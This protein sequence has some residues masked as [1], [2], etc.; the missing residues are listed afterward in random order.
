MTG[1]V[2]VK[3]LL[4]SQRYVKLVGRNVGIV[5][6][7]LLFDARKFERLVRFASSDGKVPERLLLVK[8]SEVTLA[9]E[10]WQ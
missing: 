10:G 1:I 9:R 5:P 2:P 3:S 7:N 4:F 8:F 6:T